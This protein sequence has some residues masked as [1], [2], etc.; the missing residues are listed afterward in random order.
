M[1]KVTPQKGKRVRLSVEKKLEIVEKLEKG[2]SVSSIMAEYAISRTQVYDIRATKKNLRDYSLKTETCV[3]T[4]EKKSALSI[5]SIKKPK[6]S[7]IDE[8]VYDWYREQRAEGVPVRGIELQAVA[9]RIASILN[10]EGFQASGGWLQKFSARHNISNQPIGGENSA[11]YV[12]ESDQ[13]RLDNSLLE[14][15]LYTADDET[16][17]VNFGDVDID[18]EELSDAPP[19]SETLDSSQVYPTS[20]TASPPNSEQLYRVHYQDHVSTIL[21]A[22]A[23]DEVFMDVT[24]IAEGRPIKAHKSVL[25]AMSLYFHDVLRDNPCQHPIIILPHDVL[26]EELVDLVTYIYKGEITVALDKVSSVLRVAK[27]LQINGMASVSSVSVDGSSDAHYTTS[28]ETKPFKNTSQGFR[29]QNILSRVTSQNNSA[30]VDHKSNLGRPVKRKQHHVTTTPSHQT[31]LSVTQNVTKCKKF[32]NKQNTSSL[33]SHPQTFSSTLTNV[34]PPA[35]SLSNNSLTLTNVMYEVSSV[36]GTL[37][38]ES[39]SIPG[40]S[41]TTPGDSVVIRTA[42][43]RTLPPETDSSATDPRAS[44]NTNMDMAFVDIG[45]IKEELIDVD[46]EEL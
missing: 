25:S 30:Q 7:T 33:R 15:Q 12:E 5:K 26:Y 11:Q 6:F 28:P 36:G 38:N 29:P 40:F 24:L 44:H 37:V 43:K 34:S 27:I 23:K 35:A 39:E 13:L 4:K 18:Y 2:T 41:E 19:V 10:I 46:E 31:D 32:S 45:N 22:L 21:A 16:D 9:M 42:N 8:A 20:S 3:T 17:A 1:S 14:V